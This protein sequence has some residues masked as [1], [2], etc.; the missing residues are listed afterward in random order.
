VLRHIRHIGAKHS[1]G[2]R[3]SRGSKN[4]HLTAG[5]QVSIRAAI[6]FRF[7]GRGSVR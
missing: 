5:A 3:Q 1:I 7:I 4:Q 6:A 2:S